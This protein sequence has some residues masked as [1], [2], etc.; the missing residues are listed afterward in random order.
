[1]GL[2]AKRTAETPRARSLAEPAPRVRSASAVIRVHPR[3]VVQHARAARSAT[4]ARRARSKVATATRLWRDEAVE[5][6]EPVLARAWTGCRH[7][8]ESDEMITRITKTKKGHVLMVEPA[9]PPQ[10]R[11]SRAPFLRKL[12]NN[13]QFETE[14]SAIASFARSRVA[15][16]I[17]RGA[18]H[19]TSPRGGRPARREPATADLRPRPPRLNQ[20]YPHVRRGLPLT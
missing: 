4:C 10:K 9:L 20:P 19:R 12:S 5:Y 2:N 16:L 1:M 11:R 3:L 15:A 14:Q 18:P 7:G 6:H 8:S 13:P 17:F